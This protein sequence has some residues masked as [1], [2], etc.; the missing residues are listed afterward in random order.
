MG[1]FYT[2]SCFDTP[3]V[4]TGEAYEYVKVNPLYRG[5]D[6]G[7]DQKYFPTKK[8]TTCSTEYNIVP[9]SVAILTLLCVVIGSVLIAV[10]KS[11]KME[12]KNKGTRKK[13]LTA[14]GLLIALGLLIA[15][16]YTV[17]RVVRY[18]NKWGW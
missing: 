11:K 7:T 4:W 5:T 18:G 13:I 8:T 14:G 10:D 12:P 3:Q 1:I 17:F 16:L 6:K 2:E 15:I 9:I